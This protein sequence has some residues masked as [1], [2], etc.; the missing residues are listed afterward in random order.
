MTHGVKVSKQGYNVMDTAVERD[1]KPR[2]NFVLP[3]ILYALALPYLL[4]AKT[5]VQRYQLAAS[6]LEKRPVN[7]VYD[8][9]HEASTLFEDLNTI[10]KYAEKC[11]SKNDLHQLWLD[12]RNHIRHDI[13]EEYDN[14]SSSQKNKRA[15]RL[16]LDPKLQTNI[17]FT[18]EAIKVGGI[19]IEISQIN[20]YLQWAEGLIT[21]ILNDAKAR[22]DTK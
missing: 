6:T 11:G 1:N 5:Q 2:N 22:G 3:H 4:G 20:V 21:G 17:G 15:E 16:N 10:G 18:E 14:E 12:V 9:L 8:C 19:V 13:R 7:S